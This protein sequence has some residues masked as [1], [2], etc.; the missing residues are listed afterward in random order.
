[1]TDINGIFDS[2]PR[3][4]PSA[5]KFHKL[6][7]I[8]EE[9][10]VA[11]DGTG[12]KVGTGGMKSKLMATKTALTLG[13][14]V[15][16][17]HGKGAQKLTHIIAGLGDGT[18]VG[19]HL[20]DLINTKRQWIAFHSEVAGKVYVDKGAEEALLY[21]GKSLLPAGVSKIEGT[22][23]K[24]DV[25]EVF[26][27]NTLIGKGEVSCSADELWKSLRLSSGERRKSDEVIHRDKWIKL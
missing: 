14:P 3:S 13:V 2:N 15:F 9:L 19:N 22:F 21:N 26:G 8:T 17:G 10:L 24:G 27:P 11:A 6:V 1:L 16:I 20:L 5:K 23:Q 4:N 7:E 25:V 12:S 18:Y